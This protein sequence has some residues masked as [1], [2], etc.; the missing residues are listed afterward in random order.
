MQAMPSRFD[1]GDFGSHQVHVMHDVRRWRAASRRRRGAA[2]TT[3][4]SW[5]QTIRGSNRGR[6]RR[7]FRVEIRSQLHVLME[8]RGAA[9]QFLRRIVLE[10]RSDD[11]ALRKC[12]RLRE[13]TFWE[14]S[15]YCANS[16][17]FER[18]PAGQT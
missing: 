5:R 17:H 14:C 12:R 18:L 6:G 13:H 8:Q 4:G 11:R 7:K 10:N 15:C 3:R 16:Q 9:G 2:A 1:F